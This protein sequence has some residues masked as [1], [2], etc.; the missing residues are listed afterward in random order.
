MK[1][2]ITKIL[3]GLTLT[4]GSI[5]PAMAQDATVTF[6]QDAESLF[7]RSLARYIQ[8]NYVAARDGFVQLIEEHPRNQRTSAARLMLGKSYY[9]LR[10]YNFALAA[11][12]ELYETFPYSR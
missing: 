10:E 7:Q 6:S 3:L 1:T 9:K 5:V 12:I 8:T 11:A 4:M 2:P